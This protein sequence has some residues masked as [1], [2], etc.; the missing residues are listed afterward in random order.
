MT[1][2]IA[3]DAENVRWPKPL[4]SLGDARLKSASPQL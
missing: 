4:T 2:P 1:D 3:W